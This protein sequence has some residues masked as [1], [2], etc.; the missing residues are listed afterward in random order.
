MPSTINTR[1]MKFIDNPS[2]WG[3]AWG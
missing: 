1:R 3:I 2:V